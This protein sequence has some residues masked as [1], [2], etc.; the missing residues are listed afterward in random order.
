MAPPFDGM[1]FDA[2]ASPHLYRIYGWTL[3]SERPLP[4]MQPLGEPAPTEPDIEVRFGALPEAAGPYPFARKGIRILADGTARIIAADGLRI[5]IAAGR[6]LTIDAPA[7]MTDAELH[8][9]LCGPAMAVLCH[10]R[11]QPPLHACVVDI[12]GHAVALSGNSGAGKS[13][14]ARALIRRGHRLVADD[15]AIIDPERR[16]VQPGYPSMKLWSDSAAVGDD[17]L[18]PALRVQAGIDKFHLPLNGAFQPNPTSL[19]LVFSLQTDSACREPWVREL[20]WQESTAVLH[21]LI[22]R[23][24]IAMAIDGGR[25]LFGW[26]VRI[27]GKLPVRVLYRPDDLGKLDG[28]C[29]LIERAVGDLSGRAGG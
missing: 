17:R 16:L 5:G 7:G 2:M 1:A 20:S 25:A 21:E 4:L 27:A 3:A 9:W 29:A 6:R 18:D 11:G 19:A 10:Q 26:T 14:T 23:A 24:D 12:G 22:Y 28:I 13:T 8:A 15:Q